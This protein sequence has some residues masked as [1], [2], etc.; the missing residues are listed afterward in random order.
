MRDIKFRAWS[1]SDN[2]MVYGSLN[3]YDKG[4]PLIT[5]I[6][7][8]QSW[9]VKPESVGQFTGLTDRKGIQIFDGDIVTA[10]NY[11]MY[12][13]LAKIVE[14]DN[15]LSAYVFKSK[16]VEGVMLYHAKGLEVIGNIYESPVN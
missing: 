4:N 5:N 7:G 10:E 9:S 15:D 2:K 3:L 14:W 16:N 6:E 1:I 13:H 11:S 12:K 8:T